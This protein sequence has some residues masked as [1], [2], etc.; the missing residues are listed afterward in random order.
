M[1]LQSPLGTRSSTSSPSRL[2][3]FEVALLRLCCD[4][5]LLTNE[6]GIAKYD[7]KR[8]W[9]VL[10]GSFLV[11]KSCCTSGMAVFREVI[12]NWDVGMCLMVRA[13]R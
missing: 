10:F 3:S 9:T 4:V 8:Q 2:A 1:D 13:E 12:V 7:R 6:S 5:V 11:Q